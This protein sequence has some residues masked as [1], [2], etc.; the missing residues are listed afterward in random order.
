MNKLFSSIRQ[1][2][3][4]I[5]TILKGTPPPAP[6]PAPKAHVLV[7]TGFVCFTFKGVIVVARNQ[8]EAKRMYEDKLRKQI[9]LQAKKESEAI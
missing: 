5:K 9:N 8:R 4:D 3:D 6:P 1:K 7:P 2:V